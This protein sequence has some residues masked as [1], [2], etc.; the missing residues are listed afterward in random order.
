MNWDQPEP[1]VWEAFTTRTADVTLEV[2]DP[3]EEDD[4]D[5]LWMAFSDGRVLGAGR[6]ESL[7]EAKRRCELVAA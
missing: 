3:Q 2:F 5:Y 7:E 1:G 6:A 4:G